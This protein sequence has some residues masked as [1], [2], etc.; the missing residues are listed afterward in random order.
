MM[1]L[2]LLLTACV[3]S[4]GAGLAMVGH[5]ERRIAAT[6]LRGVQT[7]YT[8]DAAVRLAIEAISQ[9]ASSSMWPGSGSVPG[10]GGGSL[11]MAIASGEAID[12]VSRTA[13]LDADAAQ[14]WPVGA[15]VPEWRL[16]GWG[17]VTGLPVSSR[18]VAVWVADDVM[19]T[20]GLPAEDGNGMLMIHVEAYGPR[21]AAHRV[22]V[23]VQ[24]EAGTVR[25][26][27]WREG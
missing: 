4:L 12:L 17:S 19:E 13:E 2:V 18:R 8:A 9:D 10:L 24:R 21:G 20:D 22:T 7:S 1:M 16:A 25:T 23:H 5:T 3:G 11:V 15:N 27:S 26:V 14:K 6:H